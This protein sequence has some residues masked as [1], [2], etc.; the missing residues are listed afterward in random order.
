MYILFHNI[1]LYH[2]ITGC[3]YDTSVSLY[4]SHGGM[5]HV[6]CI[7]WVHIC[8]YF[9]VA[10]NTVCSKS[11]ILIKN[12]YNKETFKVLSLFDADEVATVP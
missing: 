12:N 7:I 11:V 3:S 10:S 5:V 9:S 1:L 8:L 6:E 2:L 4:C